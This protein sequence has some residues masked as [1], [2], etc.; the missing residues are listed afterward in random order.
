[1]TDVPTLTHATERD[2][3]LLLVEELACS[4][5]FVAWLLARAAGTRPIVQSSEVLHSTRRMFN[6][7]EIDIRL[8]ASTDRGDVLLLIEN[9]LDADEQPDQARSYREEAET[10]AEDGLV[11]LTLLVSPDGYAASHPEFSGAFD[12]LVTY[13]EV[14]TYFE[15]AAR[16]LPALLASR[17]TYRAGLM[18]QAID[19]GRRGYV[20]VIHPGKRAFSERYVALLQ[21]MAP[22]LVP[23]PSM[24]RESAA[25]SVTMIFAPETLPK[26]PFLPRMR[27]VHQLRDANANLN[28]Y[29]WGDAWDQLSETIGAALENS[30][31][32]ALPTM[33]RRRNG[34]SS[35]KIVA[36]TP[37]V[38][39]FGDFDAQVD[40]IQQGIRA[41]AT[42]RHWM[43]E[44]QHDIREWA[45]IAAQ[46][47]N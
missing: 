43:L 35:L 37:K 16:E 22:E 9:K 45:A 39:Q 31:F 44:H 24:L 3:D 7:R 25:E 46:T 1:M 8:R 12:H 23:G 13:E 10:L 4:P 42:L 26:W 47:E 27:I 18:R 29:G 38:D 34:G 36:E 33:N 11:V 30:D 40:A 41:T 20:Q 5:D 19:R 6:R 28:F 32:H 2:I 14:E 17:M 15:S 21:E